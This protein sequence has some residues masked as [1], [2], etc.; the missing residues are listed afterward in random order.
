MRKSAISRN[1]VCRLKNR[2]NNREFSVRCYLYQ[3]GRVSQPFAGDDTL[4][5][6]QRLGT[7]KIHA[8]PKQ[9]YRIMQMRSSLVYAYTKREG[10]ALPLQVRRRKTSLGGHAVKEI[11]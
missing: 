8:H 1:I 2:P 10:I 3:R 7:Y 9:V 4:L 5:Y 6:R 11:R